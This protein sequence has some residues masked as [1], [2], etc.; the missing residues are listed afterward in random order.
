MN[1]DYM[2]QIL[3]LEGKYAVVTGG[4]SGIGRGIAISLA[5]FGASVTVLGRNAAELEKTAEQIRE[6]G[7]VCDY[8]QVD[9]SEK[10][11][12]DGFFAEY[13]KR[14]HGLD[15]FVANAGINVRAELLDTTMEQLEQL[16]NTNYK[17]TIYGLMDAGEIMKK[18]KSGSIILISSVNGVSA[19]P[20]LAVY[21][22]LKYAVEG[23]T[24]ALAASLAPY[25]VRVNSCAPGVILSKI[26][27][28]IYSVPE[29][30]EAKLA[31]I[32]LGKV[33][34]PQDIGDVVA[35]MAGDAFRF[36]TGA[37]VLVDGGELL[38]KMQKQ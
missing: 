29:I 18:Q 6:A 1:R 7:G 13:E 20:N 38:R 19:M 35:C 25:G 30:L 11:Q 4:S 2:E 33:G 37:T 31:Q 10:E 22:S 36:M 32:P 17:G 34:Q 16:L 9:I 15:I 8:A 21:S 3:G 24:R 14:G 26:N 23:L 27:E 12:V 28:A 5:H